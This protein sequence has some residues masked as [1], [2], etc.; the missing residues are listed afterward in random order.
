MHKTLAK[1]FLYVLL[2]FI[3]GLYSVATSL[4]S[5][6]GMIAIA[7][8]KSVNHLQELR[9]GFIKDSMKY[10]AIIANSEQILLLEITFLPFFLILV[11]ILHTFSS[12][13]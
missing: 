4:I 11:L 10:T 3:L 9:L 2:G 12:A 6:I 1:W 8:R 5:K 7:V 13:Q